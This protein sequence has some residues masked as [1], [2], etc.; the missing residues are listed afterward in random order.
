VNAFSWQDLWAT[1]DQQGKVMMD[2]GQFADAKNTFERQDWQAASA[3]RAGE[4]EQAATLYQSVKNE[5]ADYNQGNAL[6]QTGKY[7]QAIK[8]YDNALRL[9]SNNKDALHN[10]RI[11]EDLLK[12][13]TQQQ[14]NKD[15]QNQDKQNQDKQNQDKQNQDKQNQDKQNQDKQNQDKQNQD[16]QQAA[17]FWQ[18]QLKEQQLQENIKKAQKADISYQNDNKL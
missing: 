11:V 7:E 14:K 2:K 12:K 4:Y 16:K 9:N 13:Q 1:K 10:R 15:K 6:A 5:D 8:A 3:Y 18:Q 17:T